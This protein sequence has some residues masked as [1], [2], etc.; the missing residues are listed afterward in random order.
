MKKKRITKEIESI[1]IFK[2]Y[3]VIAA[4]AKHT[5]IYKWVLGVAFVLGAVDIAID[6]T[7]SLFGQVILLF[8]WIP[9]IAFGLVGGVIHF[10]TGK[11]IKYLQSKYELSEE[12]VLKEI[13]L[14]F[15]KK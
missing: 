6:G 7:V 5:P 3:S 2:A 11:K 8:A 10:L 13:D 1:G 9:A 12:S 4:I 14:A 15:A